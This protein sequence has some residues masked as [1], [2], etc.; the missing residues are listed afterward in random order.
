MKNWIK[1]SRFFYGIGVAGLGVQQFIYPD[2]RPVIWPPGWPSWIHSST[3]AYI[4]G[5]ALI[6]AAILI[7][8]GKKAKMASL[9]LGLFLLII[10]L[11]I[12][13]TYVLFVQPNFP[14]H[15]ALWTDPLKELALSGGA[16]VLAQ[17]CDDELNASSRSLLSTVLKK[18]I[19]F[20]M[21]FFS[22][23][24]ISFGI[25]HFF[26]TE[27]V[28]GLVPSWFPDHIFWTYFAGVALIGSGVAI[29]LEIRVERV[30]ALLSTMLFLWFVLLH[31]P[32]AIADPYGLQGNEISSVFEALTFS[33]IALGIA[34]I[35][36]DKINPTKNEFTK[37]GL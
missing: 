14:R 19:P 5:A 32:R 34:I 27:F 8:A 18:L 28:A 29:I 12:Q 6:T 11:L 10:F 13:C 37:Q 15:L 1:I 33:G 31:I 36:K 3:W 25:D 22:I 16:F 21:I 26:Y 9:L 35:Y 4:V 23:T 7:I 30:A 24:M 20:G 17:L 2:L